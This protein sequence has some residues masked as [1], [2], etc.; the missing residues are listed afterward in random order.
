VCYLTQELPALSSNDTF[1][2]SHAHSGFRA[3]RRCNLDPSVHFQSGE[4]QWQ[5]TMIKQNM[6][7]H[8]IVIRPITQLRLP[9]IIEREKKITYQRLQK[10]VMI[11][12]LCLE[13]S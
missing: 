2:S 12:Q 9:Y 11:H 10:L 7:V 6:K 13:Q 1:L 8:S 3:S 5:L 4:S